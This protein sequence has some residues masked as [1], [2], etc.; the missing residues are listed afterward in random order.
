VARRPRAL[1]LA[2]HGGT[3]GREEAKGERCRS[4]R[5]RDKGE[6]E[7]ERERELEINKST[8]VGVALFC[9]GWTLDPGL[10]SPL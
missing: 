5:E 2:G 8:R 7:R 10:N 4:L 6:R 9:P 3:E 1:G